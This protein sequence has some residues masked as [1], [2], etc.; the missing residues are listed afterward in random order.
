M[1]SKTH[2]ISIP[3]ILEIGPNVLESTGHIL[4]EE[5]FKEV[6][7]CT[8]EFIY[9]KIKET[10]EASLKE[11]NLKFSVKLFDPACQIS[12]LTTFAL[13]MSGD[14]DVVLGIGGGS[15][16]DKAKYAS[17]IRKK[18]YVS[19]TTSPS[20]DGF[21]SPVASLYVDNKRTT[22]PAKIP[23][24][25]L[26]DTSIIS[27]VPEHMIYSGIGDSV[28]NYTAIY[29]LY[30]EKERRDVNLDKFS[31]LISKRSIES[32]MFGEFKD[33]RDEGFINNLMETLMMSGI[34]MEIAGTSS[35]ASGSE[36]LISHALDKLLEQN[37][38]PHGIQVGIAT[39]IVAR[40]QDNEMTD[41]IDMFLEKTGFWTYVK[42]LN[43]KASVFTES[44]DIAPSI[45]E[46]RKTVMHDEELR[47]KAKFVIL[48]DSRLNDV[49]VKG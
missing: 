41:E 6:L 28:S 3:T 21:S 12:E 30:Y 35:P 49:L 8:D 34:S 42:S 1:K 10:L 20:N 23:Y 33:I 45:K 38:Y 11:N 16:L 47:E 5:G 32:L 40:V 19:M 39:Y 27:E 31:A 43:I 22:V 48:N 29:D 46:Y 13:T 4:A 9:N 44:I 36:H 14:I 15:V 24:G 18:V 2:R 7:I 17:F 37:N 26:A 25:V